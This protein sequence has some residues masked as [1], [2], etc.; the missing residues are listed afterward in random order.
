MEI[1]YIDIV[2]STNDEVA[3]RNCGGML[4][5]S[6]YQTKGRGQRGNSW[7]SKAGENLTF[8]FLLKPDSMKA[9]RQF[10]ISKIVALS[11]VNTL[12][13]YGILADVKWPNDIYVGDKKISGIL[14]E[15][16]LS[17]SGYLSKIICGVGLNVNQTVFHS[18][19]PN[20]ISMQILLSQPLNR[21]AVL[22][23]FCSE[24]EKLYTPKNVECSD[25]IDCLY[26]K[27]LY[28]RGQFHEFEDNDGVFTGK[29]VG[30]G[31]WGELLV[32]RKGDNAIKSYLFKD[33]KYIIEP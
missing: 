21:K 19:A 7:E 23:L 11:V 10:T 15:N 4:I 25:I 14:I 1:V 6:D 32:E 8:S 20:P 22:D 27:N 31:D 12:E 30:I 5:Y 2:S 13:R 17:S 28:R 29:I 9:D 16:V 18:D 3:S 24:F 33:V 26:L